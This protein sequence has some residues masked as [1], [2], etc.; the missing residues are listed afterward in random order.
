M[1][2]KKPLL[3]LEAILKHVTK[4]VFVD[5]IASKLS[6]KAISSPNLPLEA[7][8]QLCSIKKKHQLQKFE[9]FQK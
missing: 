3:G 5:Y 7:L 6:D 9:E 4:P 1:K 2:N 8:E